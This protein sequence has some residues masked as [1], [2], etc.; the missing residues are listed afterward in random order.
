[1]TPEPE[2]KRDGPVAIL[3][4]SGELPILLA[5]RLAALGRPYRILAFKGFCRRTLLSRADAVV[6]L[7]E[8]RRVQQIL[9][10]WRPAALTL[11]G[12]LTRPSPAALLGAIA[13][14]RDRAA[15]G[16]IIARGDDNLLRGAIRLLEADGHAVIGVR[17]LA[18]DLLAVT[19]AYG[20]R[21]PSPRHESEIALGLRL[22]GDISAYDIGQAAVIA[23][24][25]VLAIEGPEGTDRMLGRARRLGGWAW[26]VRRRSG[27]GVLVKAPKRG[28]DL[29]VDLPAI[30]PRTVENASRAG[31]DGIAIASGFTLVIERDRTV[32]IAD[33][34]GLF[35]TAVPL[36]GAA[37]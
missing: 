5:D 16:E 8:I 22:L 26:W 32:A 36:D 13:G 14:L 18:P 15:L 34:L 31:L 11:A 28:Q 37:S 2:P 19:G 29:R 20:A 12:G 33:R 27:G 30:G 35:L 25:R 24:E 7:L 21:R 17:D 4:G 23:G 1:M 6:G 10:S 3:A 9:G